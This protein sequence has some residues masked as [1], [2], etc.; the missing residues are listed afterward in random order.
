MSLGNDP[1]FLQYMKMFFTAFI[2]VVRI[3]AELGVKSL[4]L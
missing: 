2:R 1:A 3:S 4:T